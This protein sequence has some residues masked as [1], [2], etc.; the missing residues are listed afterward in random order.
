[1]GFPNLEYSAFFWEFLNLQFRSFLRVIKG[2]T[3]PFTILRA[4]DTF[5]RSYFFSFYTLIFCFRSVKIDVSIFAQNP[6]IRHSCSQANLLR[7]R[8]ELIHSEDSHLSSKIKAKKCWILQ[9]SHHLTCPSFRVKH[10]CITIRTWFCLELEQI[11]DHFYYTNGGYLYSKSG[12]RFAI[13]Q[14][15]VT[16]S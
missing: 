8:V 6:F 3:L 16:F 4:T 11:W 10:G 14:S 15:I 9:N 13:A 1:M 5:A 12:L 2:Q 7:L